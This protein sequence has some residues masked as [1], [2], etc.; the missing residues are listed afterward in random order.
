MNAPMT[1]P[2]QDL[3]LPSRFNVSGLP[4]PDPK[5]WTA[6]DAAKLMPGCHSQELMNLMVERFLRADSA[7][8]VWADV[9]KQCVEFLEGKQWSAKEIA[10]AEQDDRPLLTLNKLAPLVRL[11]LGYH[12]NNRMDARYLP[13]SD[14]RSSEAI[15]TVL[16]KVIKS[17]NIGLK[18]P[19]ID[20]E[21]F[22]DGISTGRGYYDWRLDFEHNDFGEMSCKAKDP[23]TLRLDPDADTYEPK[24]WNYQFDARWANIDEIEH[25]FGMHVSALVMPLIRS[26]GYRGGVPADVMNYIDEATPWRT[27][28]GNQDDRLIGS[29]SVESYISNS[30]D[31]YRKNIRLIECQH[32]IRVMQRNIVDLETGDRQ[33]VPTNFTAD[34]MKKVMDWAAEQYWMRG[35]ECPLR[36]EW[37]PT[38]RIR[39]TT[40]VGDIIIYDGWSPYE[41][42]T[43][44]P[45]FPYFRRG[46]TRGM[47]EDLVGPQRELNLRRSSQTDILTRVAHSGWMWHKDS[48]DEAEKE[49]MENHGAAAGINIEWKGGPDMKPERIE[50]GQMPS[51]IKDLEISATQDLKEIAGINDSALGQ[52]DRVQSGRAIEAR[53]KQSVLGIEMYMDN[54]RRTKDLCAEKQLEMLQNHYTEPRVF[55]HMGPDGGWSTIAINQR[56][57]VG[58]I[59]N[60]VNVGKYTVSVDE[61]PISSTWLNAQF[62]ELVQLVE[63]GIIPAAMVQDIMVDLSSAPQK[64]LIKLRLNA[65][66]KAQGM[67]TADELAAAVQ[68]GIPVAPAAIPQAG[69]QGSAG[70]PGGGGGGKPGEKKETPQG[71]V[72][73]NIGAPPM[74]GQGG[75]PAG[76]GP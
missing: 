27:F 13:S 32:K 51:A 61:T 39:W 3:F 38:K 24:G 7:L 28:G 71:N 52:I 72:N 22:L 63:K 62:E 50:P 31:P 48:L 25:N 43:T 17:I 15:A 73:V 33:P 5:H 34:Q 21:V 10:E 58:E 41:T 14:A 53:Q 74:S 55:K 11:V 70:Q 65:F 45:F 60:N 16:T 66:L 57:A 36:V 35:Q 49:K 29:N 69:P 1:R 30:I 64:E 20:T 54:A 68:Q 46:K 9:A 12:R 44:V 75:A 56:D 2:M 76:V 26:N 59:I 67:V 19:Y 37:R 23:F 40:M 8:S 18:M 47:V 6:D 4:S 42:F